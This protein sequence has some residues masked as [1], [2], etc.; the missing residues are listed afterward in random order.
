[1]LLD[2]GL[3]GA[4]VVVRDFVHDAGDVLAAAVPGGLL[5]GWESA[6]LNPD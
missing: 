4:P 3:A 5:C 2:L 6:H 1:M